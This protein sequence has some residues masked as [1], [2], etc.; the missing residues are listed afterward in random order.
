MKPHIKNALKGLSK[1]D[2]YNLKFKVNHDT[3]TI[4]ISKN[5]KLAKA[6]NNFI[7]EI[8]EFFYYFRPKTNEP[9]LAHHILSTYQ[10]LI[11]HPDF[12]RLSPKKQNI[13]EYAALLHDLGKTLDSNPEHAKLSVRMIQARLEKLGLIKKDITDI[14]KLVN[15]HHY[16]YNIK[17]NIK[18]FEYYANKHTKK[19]FKSL[20][21]LV[22]AD[23]SSKERNQKNID[24]IKENKGYFKTQ[25][26]LYKTPKEKV[27]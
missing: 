20:K 2:I 10:Q 16:S 12:Q 6:I 13:L 22:D 24:R 26:K 27:A 17:N 1:K 7:K 3:K 15:D 11:Q 5:P 25:K 14:C 9:D 4:S 18:T 21:I 19:D 23:V 8:P